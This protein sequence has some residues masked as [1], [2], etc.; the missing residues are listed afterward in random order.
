MNTIPLS[1]IMSGNQMQ[2]DAITTSLIITSD[3]HLVVPQTTNGVL[4]PL[5]N[6][7]KDG[8]SAIAVD[9]LPLEAPSFENGDGS[10]GGGGSGGG[11]AVNSVT[12][13]NTDTITIGGTVSDPTVVANTAAVTTLSPNLATG[14]QIAAYVNSLVTSPYQ[15]QGA[16]DPLTNTPVLASPPVTAIPLSQGDAFVVTQAATSGASLFFGQAL[17]ALD[18]IVADV[19]IP[20]GTTTVLADYTIIERNIDIATETIP[21]LAS[22]PTSGGL[23]VDGAGAVSLETIVPPVTGVYTNAD[24]TVDDKGRVVTAASGTAG[25]M[26]SWQLSGDS[27]GS[28]SVTDADNVQILGGSQ[29]TTVSSANTTVTIDLASSLN[30][31]DLTVT[32]P[33]NADITGSAS[34]A[35]SATTATSAG[36]VTNPAQPAITSVGTLTGLT[37]TNT[38]S[39]SING[40]ANT[41]NSAGFANSAGSAGSA[42][43]ANSAGIVTNPAQPNITSVGTLT[44]LTVTNT[45][46]GS[47]NGNANTA[48][49]AGF[50]NSA[51]SA[52][53]ATT[54]N[55]AGVVTNPA[56]PNITSTGTLQNF[57]STGIDDNATSNAMTIDSQQN[58]QFRNGPFFYGSIAHDRAIIVGPGT[59]PQSQSSISTTVS[60]FRGANPGGANTEGPATWIIAI[61]VNYNVGVYYHNLV[62][63]VVKSTPWWNNAGDAWTPVQLNHHNA[64]PVDVEISFNATPSQAGQTQQLKIRTISA[65]FAFT[66]NITFTGVK[67]F[68]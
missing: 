48:N 68:Q 64:N 67:L 57:T 60:T 63:S 22:F 1:S 10:S 36:V 40:N 5:F 56:Q 44:G 2:R 18:I 35:G 24:I 45:I 43:T 28:Q 59:I 13:G 4:N 6:N 9:I 53:S 7:K 58:V 65:P 16:Y 49:S 52:G 54:A 15:F 3:P 19:N 50:A 14:S 55:S 46:S 11:G 23:V 39:G 31:T 61:K 34:S 47:I 12:S 21:G 27:G 42:T 32:N 26:S 38:I 51:G 41:A 66:G 62:G 17:S 37:V 29:I 30:L 20:V 8:K 25:T 33:I